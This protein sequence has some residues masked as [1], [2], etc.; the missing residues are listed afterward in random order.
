MNG[1]EAVAIRMV[2]AENGFI[3]TLVEMHGISPDDARRALDT[4]RKHK[5]VKLDAVIGRYIAKT[6]AI[7]DRDV[8][9]RA[10]TEGGK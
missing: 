10:I 5:L 9:D 1:Y 8:V 4:Y 2:N 3:D 6:G 7:F